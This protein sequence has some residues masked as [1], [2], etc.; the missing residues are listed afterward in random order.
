VLAFFGPSGVLLTKDD[1]LKSAGNLLFSPCSPIV[2]QD[3]GCHKCLNGLKLQ[4]NNRMKARKCEK[5][6]KFEIVFT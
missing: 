2:K 6:P 3:C 5:L 1:V 4:Q